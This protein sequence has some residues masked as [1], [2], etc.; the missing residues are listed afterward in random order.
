[1]LTVM[2][3][4]HLGD[5]LYSFYNSTLFEGE[6]LC[7][8]LL[9]GLCYRLPYFQIAHEKIKKRLTVPQ[10]IDHDCSCLKAGY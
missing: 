5:F 3:P 6:E 7:K 8:M 9:G 4:A 2:S 10:P 1:M